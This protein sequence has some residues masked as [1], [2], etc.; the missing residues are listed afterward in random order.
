MTHLKVVDFDPVSRGPSPERD[1]VEAWLLR[2][3]TEGEFAEFALVTP[4]L[5]TVLLEGNDRNRRIKE[6]GPKNSVEAY[7]AAMLRDEWRVNGETIVIS[8]TGRLLDG[9][10]RVHA[11][12]D[13]G[14]PIKMLLVFGIEDET[15]ATLDQG[16][17]R[18][19]SDRLQLGGYK[20]TSVLGTVIRYVWCYDAAPAFRDYPSADQEQATLAANPGMGAAINQADRVYRV[21]HISRP[22]L[23]A[24]HVLC[25][26]VDRV[27][28]DRFLATVATGVGIGGTRDPAHRL[29][30]AFQLHDS[31]R[32]KLDGVEQ[33]ALYIKAFNAYRTGAPMGRLDWV[34]R[35]EDFPVAG[36]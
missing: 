27:A 16:R 19:A 33:M 30:S 12:R 5:A 7:A 1:Q 26:R 9:Q 2:G 3:R 28:A 4:G 20:N 29:R 11:V 31:G 25:Q 35:T 34:R 14:V 8:R 15:Q 32:G 17:V 22:A 23:T 21:F 18:T 10:H 6:K 36:G 13:S 24:A